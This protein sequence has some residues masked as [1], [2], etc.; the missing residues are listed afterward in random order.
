MPPD[1]DADAPAGFI[2]LPRFDS[3]PML[4][5]DAFSDILL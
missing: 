2:R 5:A 4:F 3:M 1:I